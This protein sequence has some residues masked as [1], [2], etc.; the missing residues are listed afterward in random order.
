MKG[1]HRDVE[2]LDDEEGVHAV[3][4]SDVEGNHDTHNGVGARGVCLDSKVMQG[5]GAQDRLRGATTSS[6]TRRR[7]IRTDR[8]LASPADWPRPAHQL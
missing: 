8:T 6:A 2:E 1:R 5:V 7:Q 3:W 4:I